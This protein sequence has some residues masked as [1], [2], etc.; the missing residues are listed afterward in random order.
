MSPARFII[1]EV[2]IVV[3]TQRLYVFDKNRYRFDHFIC[4]VVRLDKDLLSRKP[5]SICC[6][7]MSAY[8]LKNP[9]CI[10]YVGVDYTCAAQISEKNPILPLDLLSFSFE[11]ISSA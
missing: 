7:N 5:Y 9:T 6:R 3:D 10:V 2:D 11:L 1:S 4:Y 8:W